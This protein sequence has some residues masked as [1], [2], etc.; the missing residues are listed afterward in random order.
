MTRPTPQEPDPL[1]AELQSLRPVGPSAEL[2]GRVARDLSAYAGTPRPKLWL[3]AGGL[4]AAACVVAGAA[5]ALRGIGNPRPRERVPV[6]STAPAAGPAVAPDG[7]TGPVADD[8][9]ALANYRRA[10][11]G[12]PEDLDALLDRQA[13]RPFGGGAGGP[14]AGRVT[15]SSDLG[16]LP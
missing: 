3:A 2:R 1:E 13:A 11:A 8:R 6:V 10:L 9:P 16:L 7:A 5:V 4:A 14:A 12:P 15:A